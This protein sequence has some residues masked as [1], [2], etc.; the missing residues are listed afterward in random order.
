[1]LDYNCRDIARVLLVTCCFAAAFALP[2]RAQADVQ[3]AR[4]PIAA[5]GARNQRGRRETLPRARSRAAPQTH[6]LA[7][8]CRCRCVCRQLHIQCPTGDGAPHG[9]RTRSDGVRGVPP[10]P[11]AVHPGGWPVALLRECPRRDREE[12]RRRA[13]RTASRR[14]GI[15]DLGAPTFREQRGIGA[16]R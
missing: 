11:Q 12:G 15:S 4:P 7:A 1:M 14:I 13:R 6:V 9:S 3:D 2:R 10:R 5:P 16:A 8:G